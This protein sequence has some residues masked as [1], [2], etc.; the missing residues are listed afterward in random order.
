MF[1]HVHQSNNG[2]KIYVNELPKCKKQ[3]GYLLSMMEIISE[4]TLFPC[5]LKN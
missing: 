3:F 2:S 5:T 1:E 4:S